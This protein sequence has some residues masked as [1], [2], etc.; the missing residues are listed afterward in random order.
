MT[1]QEW[2]YIKTVIMV[3]RIPQGQDKL[4]V[5][6]KEDWYTIRKFI[7]KAIDMR[8]SIREFLS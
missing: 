1:D 8:T 2:E 6:Q 3:A 7:D 5:L 4:I